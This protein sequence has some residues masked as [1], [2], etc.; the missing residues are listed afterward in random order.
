MWNNDFVPPIL[1]RFHLG[2][3]QRCFHSCLGICDQ[4]FYYN[5]PTIC[6]P[7]QPGGGGA[8]DAIDRCI[9][10]VCTHNRIMCQN[11]HCAKN[12]WK[13]FSPTACIGEVFSWRKFLRIRYI[14]VIQQ[15]NYITQQSSY[16]VRLAY[17]C[18]LTSFAS[19]FCL[20][21]S[22]ALANLS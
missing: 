2:R 22:S 5:M 4:T 17:F 3:A 10:C 6:F 19:P 1:Q 14:I 15:S 9:I 20:T 7:I 18:S 16:S 13:R 21:A 8:G 12:S 11:F